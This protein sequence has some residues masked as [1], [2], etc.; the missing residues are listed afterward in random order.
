MGGYGRPVRGGWLGPAVVLAV[1]LATALA[2]CTAT[3]PGSGTAAPTT[4]LPVPGTGLDV[5]VL[6]DEYLLTAS[7]LGAL[8]GTPVEPPR[9]G[10]VQ[11][12]DGSSSSSC[13]AASGAEPVA[14]INVYA[15]RSG[16]PADHLRGVS[17]TGGRR[18]L[19]GV[20]GPPRWSRRSGGRRCSSR[21]RATS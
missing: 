5:D 7:E 6:P 13:S 10:A 17:A 12:G 3:V 19:P 1:A 9:Q 14:M 15:T 11:R 2:G 8:V 20:G 21:A 16:T 18:D 4:R